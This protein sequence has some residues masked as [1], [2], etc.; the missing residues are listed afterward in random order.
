MKF[1]SSDGE[2]GVLYP[3]YVVWG[4]RGYLLGPE[5]KEYHQKG[6]VA[7]PISMRVLAAILCC[8]RFRVSRGA[9]DAVI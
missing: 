7:S 6:E 5:A 8:H 4:P 3:L 1:W 2:G 9:V